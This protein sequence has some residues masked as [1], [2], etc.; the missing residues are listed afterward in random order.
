MNGEA[1]GEGAII[2]IVALLL[3]IGWVL[4]KIYGDNDDDEDR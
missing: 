4:W 2:V 3:L 1:T